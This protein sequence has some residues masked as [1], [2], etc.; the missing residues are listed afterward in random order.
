[1]E[2]G[3]VHGEALPW[4]AQGPQLQAGGL[5]GVDLAAELRDLAVTEEAAQDASTPIG[6]TAHEPLAGYPVAADPRALNR[7]GA[8]L[9]EHQ[10]GAQHRDAVSGPRGCGQHP[11]VGVG[12]ASDHLAG[13]AEPQ[14]LGAGQGDRAKPAAAGADLGQG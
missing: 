10:G 1:M 2:L 3:I 5:A 14:G 4:G 13:W 8:E 11:G 12:A 7:L 6:G 9:L